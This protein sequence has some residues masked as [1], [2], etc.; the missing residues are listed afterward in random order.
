M[1]N[2]PEC[3]I[4]TEG[5]TSEGGCRWALCPDCYRLIIEQARDQLD[6]EIERLKYDR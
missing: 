4:Q 3:N 1:H 2:C 6:D 5:T